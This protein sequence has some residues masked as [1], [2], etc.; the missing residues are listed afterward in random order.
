MIVEFKRDFHSECAAC[1]SIRHRLCGKRRSRN[2]E[3][4]KKTLMWETRL[5]GVYNFR[6]YQTRTVCWHAL[7]RH[8]MKEHLNEHLSCVCECIAP[9][10]QADEVKN[11]NCQWW[12]VIGDSAFGVC[13]CAR[14]CTSLCS[15]YLFRHFLPGRCGVAQNWRHSSPFYVCAPWMD[16]SHNVAIIKTNTFRHVYC[17]DFVVHETRLTYTHVH[18]STLFRVNVDEPRWQF[19]GPDQRSPRLSFASIN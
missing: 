19:V 15:R 7:P 8:I 11:L 3:E 2:R 5:S 9:T 6:K 10:C 18:P 14:S 4:D 16:R 13:V 17:E 1:V 12:M